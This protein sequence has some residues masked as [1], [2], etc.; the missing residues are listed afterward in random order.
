MPIRH[1]TVLPRVR[2]IELLDGALINQRD[3]FLLIRETFP[4]FVPRAEDAAAYGYVVL[5]RTPQDLR[6]EDFLG[7]PVQP[8]QRN[9]PDASTV[10]SSEVIDSLPL[11]VRGDTSRMVRTLIEGSAADPAAFG[12]VEIPASG[13]TQPDS[14]LLRPDGRVR[15]W[16]RVHRRLGGGAFA[17]FLPRRGRRSLLLYGFQFHSRR[18][19]AAKLPSRCRRRRRTRWR[20]RRRAGELDS[21]RT[22]GGDR[23]D[24]RVHRSGPRVLQR[25]PGQFA[26]G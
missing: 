17:A 2:H 11:A 26:R 1:P 22:S 13:R 20:L 21:R 24:L 16:R 7:S 3:L 6:D 8:V 4:S 23:S 12:L 10:C 14:L 19:V 5:R 15:W 9:P 25:Q 18:P